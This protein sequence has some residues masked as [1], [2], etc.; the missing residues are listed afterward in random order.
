MN[1]QDES[2]DFPI[3][4]VS[5]GNHGAVSSGCGSNNVSV[6]RSLD[7]VT[8]IGETFK[9]VGKAPETN[10]K[11]HVDKVAKPNQGKM[12]QS[13]CPETIVELFSL[14]EM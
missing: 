2:I 4:E 10:S 14:A 6:P 1:E 5:H 12:R 7:V 11:N 9:A 8:G 3:D 13:L